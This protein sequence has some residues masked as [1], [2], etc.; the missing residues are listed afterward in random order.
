MD[1]M[2]QNTPLGEFLRVRR[3]RLRP[4]DAGLTWQGAR[5]VPGLRREEL[6]HLAGVSSTYYTRLEQGQ[7]TRASQSVLD[8]LA[9]ALGLSEDERAH[10]HNRA[11]PA[12]SEPR[13]PE[14]PAAARR[15]TLQLIEALDDVPAVVL[16]IRGEVL[17]WNRLGHLLLAATLST[18]HPAG[19]LVALT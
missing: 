8:A 13:R 4:E 5:R 14:P 3:A 2:G 18:T 6:A 15:G 17:A 9:R 12:P 10:L 1:A 7:S 11:R 16:G 19:R